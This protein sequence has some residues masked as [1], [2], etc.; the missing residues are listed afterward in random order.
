MV[1][2]IISRNES[3]EVQLEMQPKL[4]VL[5]KEQQQEPY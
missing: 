1:C 5:S 2:L 3:F 4:V